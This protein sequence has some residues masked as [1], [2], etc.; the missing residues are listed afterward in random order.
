M[1][2]PPNNTLSACVAQGK[3]CTALGVRFIGQI[4][5][6]QIAKG[7]GYD[8]IFLDLEHSAFTLQ[9]AWQLCQVANMANVSPFA[10]VPGETGNGYIQRVLDGDARGIIFPHSHTA[11]LE[12]WSQVTYAPEYYQTQDE[13]D[14]FIAHG[15]EI[16]SQIPEGCSLIDLGSGDLRRIRPLLKFIEKSQNR[17]HYYALDLSEAALKRGLGQSAEQFNVECTRLWGPF[18]R[19]FSWVKSLTPG[20]KWLLS[21]GSILGNGP[22]DSAAQGLARW[23]SLMGPDVECYVAWILIRTETRSGSHITN[24]RDAMRDM[25]AMDR[26][27]QTHS[28]DMTGMYRRIGR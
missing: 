1:V 28:L 14:L 3:L 11:W 24:H 20:P 5:I 10:R 22:V 18:E 15:Q 12:L 4:E 23:A 16:V 9:T 26:P 17:V 8:S 13:V 21:L 6:V 19:C 7:A 2:L 25:F 27:I